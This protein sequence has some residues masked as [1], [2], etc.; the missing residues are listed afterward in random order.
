M[1][2]WN[3]LPTGLVLR[4]MRVFRNRYHCERC[5]EHW[6]DEMLTVS[7]SWCPFCESKREPWDYEELIV[8]M[9]CDA[10]EEVE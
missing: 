10:D 2:Q 3:T 6:E 8:D 4:P 9:L 1:P 5:G 7:H